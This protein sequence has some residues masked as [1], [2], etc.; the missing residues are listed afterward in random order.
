MHGRI[1]KEMSKFPANWE[2]I[3]LAVKLRD[4]IAPETIMLGNGD[5]TSYQDGLDKVDQFGVDG[6][7]IGRGIFKNPWIFNP[8]KTLSTVPLNER[9]QLL[10][11]HVE[12]FKHDWVD[13]AESNG[14]YKNYNLL[15]KFFKIYLIELND[16]DDL[17]AK[18]M[19]TQSAEECLQLLDDLETIFE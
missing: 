3:G 9:L 6:V 8:D 4:Q 15:K 13:N 11:Y 5:V 19:E 12:L 17:R 1:A 16:V 2:Q 7:M 10:R 14:K 18:L